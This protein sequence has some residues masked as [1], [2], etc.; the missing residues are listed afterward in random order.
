MGSK[1]LDSLYQQFF[2]AFDKAFKNHKN[3]N[4]QKKAIEEWKNAKSSYEDKNQFVSHI[5]HRINFY[6]QTNNLEEEKQKR[7]QPSILNF[8]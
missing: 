2:K 5:Q 1:D 8:F 4:V 3:E 6:N 7:M